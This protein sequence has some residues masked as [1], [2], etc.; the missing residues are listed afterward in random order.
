VKAERYIFVLRRNLWILALCVVAFT[1]VR[2]QYDPSFSHYWA[3]ETAYNPAAVGK[4][5]KVNIDV[6]YNMSLVGFEN[7]PKTMYAAA[8]MP[9]YLFGAYHGVGAKFTNDKIGLFSHNSFSIQYAFKLKLLGGMLSIGVQPALLGEKFD[10]SKL[11]LEEAS[12]PAFS[13]SELSG[14]A[15]DLAAGLHYQHRYWNV[16]FGVQH[17]LAPTIDLGETNELEVSRSYYLI[18][19]GN[20][21]LRNPFLSIQP[22]VMGRTDGVAYRADVTVRMTYQH[23]KRHMYLGVGYS[24]T[25]SVTVYLGGSFHGIGIG[26]SYEIY[27]N[28]LK[29]GNGS[30]EL[31]V[32]YQTDLNLFKKGRNRH[33][34]VRI[35]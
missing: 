27:T 30:H 22:S 6:A 29:L 26:Y 24:P 11:D 35:L 16:G 4:Q 19:G 7:N 3:M 1:E 21:R 33:Q 9:F 12:D 18:A 28:G 31:K 5:S 2:A 23:E 34:S 8:D 10:G 25:N 14:S 15:F 20:I 17:I 13:T 32:N